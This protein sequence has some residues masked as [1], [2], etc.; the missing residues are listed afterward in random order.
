MKRKDKKRRIDEAEAA[1]AETSVG[2]DGDAVA[3]GTWEPTQQEIDAW[4]AKVKEILQKLE[5][6]A[7]RTKVVDHDSDDKQHSE[8]AA[9]TASR[10]CSQPEKLVRKTSD[11]PV[12]RNGKP[13]EPYG[14]S[15]PPFLRA[16]ADGDLD[17]LR[18]MVSDAKSNDACGSRNNNKKHGVTAEAGEG[19]NGALCELLNAR[20]RHGST[21]EHWAA[22]GGHLECLK[23][24]VE[25]AAA[26]K[27]GCASSSSIPSGEAETKVRRRDGKTSLHYAA[28]NGRVECLRYL[29][30]EIGDGNAVEGSSRFGVD[31]RSGDGTTP[32][33]L[34]CF[35]G[36]AD[37]V[38]YLLD[39]GANPKVAND[40]G[41]TAAHWTGLTRRFEV[42]ND[43]GREI[44][45]LC[46][47]LRDHGVS[48]AE[49]QRHGHSV[50]HKAAQRKNRFVIEWM[51][52]TKQEG[53]PGLSKSEC[54]Q[55]S[56]PDDG[57]HRPS[58]IW[59]AAGGIE[60]F[61]RWMREE[62]NW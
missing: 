27:K 15:L 12:D 36:H 59:L 23:Y 57:G 21:A 61:A 43:D 62:M 37:A 45:R 41:C 24:L 38:K 52:R 60:E 54:F 33:H 17:S 22:G 50:L 40:W 49:T 56:K 48:F 28:R 8:S 26:A 55:V 51:A 5:E 34:A 4:D 42:A 19:G 7:H 47:L 29:L 16:A 3:T 58:D 20:D 44:Y 53:G 6:E 35:G 32:L 14:K 1:V 13:V 10:K 11:L 46:N 2:A 30:E 18:E 39:R 9:T 25:V 31:E